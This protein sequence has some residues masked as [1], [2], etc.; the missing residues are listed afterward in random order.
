M[1]D[2]YR[3]IPCAVQDRYERA[4]ITGQPLSL[5]WPSGDLRLN[6]RVRILDL[7]TAQG[8]EYVRFA[9]RHGRIHR[10]RL[11]HVRLHDD[12]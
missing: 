7:E 11:D 5:D 6:D 8:A 12:P 2:A 1:D 3:P 9:D 10:V 4:I